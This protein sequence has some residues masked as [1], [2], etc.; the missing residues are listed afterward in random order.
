MQLHI[1]QLHIKERGLV[2][3]FE[4]RPTSCHQNR[5]IG[6]SETKY[7]TTFLKS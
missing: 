2:P 3:A 6:H 4:K 1:R 7:V 5:D